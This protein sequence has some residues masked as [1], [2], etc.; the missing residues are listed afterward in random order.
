MLDPGSC[1]RAINC[2]ELAPL[3]RASCLAGL[4]GPAAHTHRRGV[5][6]LLSERKDLPACP[7]DGCGSPPSSELEGYQ[8]P[9]TVFWTN[10][11]ISLWDRETHSLLEPQENLSSTLTGK[12]YP[13]LPT[14]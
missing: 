14:Q 13:L 2:S 1:W 7:I 4:V 6:T 3:R 8:K 11:A 10:V 5:D 12:P 9:N